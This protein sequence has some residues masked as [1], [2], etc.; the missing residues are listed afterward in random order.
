MFSFSDRSP[1]VMKT[2]YKA[3]IR[4]LLEYSC[5]VW[6]GLSLENIRK[7][8]AIQRSFTDKIICP[9]YV[10]NYW[11]RLQYLNLMS[12]QRRRERYSVLH[13]WKILNNQV[14]NDLEISFYENS[15]LG[16]L[17]HVPPLSSNSSSKAQHLYDASLAVTGPKLWNLLPKSVK[18]CSSLNSFKFNLDNFLKDIPDR[19]PVAGYVAQNNNSLLE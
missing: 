7:V 12:L 3:L 10:S 18:C 11:E 1:L 14:S 17:A 19:P 4:S 5:P 16:I 6:C 13:M 15:R 2:L 8:E 9:A